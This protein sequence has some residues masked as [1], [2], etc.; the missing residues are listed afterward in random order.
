MAL[1]F[2]TASARVLPVST[3]RVGLPLA[4]RPTET[5]AHHRPSDVRW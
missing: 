5:E 2:L 4:S 3:L 1:S